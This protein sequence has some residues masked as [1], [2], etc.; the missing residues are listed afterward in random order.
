MPGTSSASGLMKMHIAIMIGLV[1]VA[2]VVVIVL[3][4][5]PPAPVPVNVY[6]VNVRA[7]DIEDAWVLPFKVTTEQAGTHVPIQAVALR[8]FTLSTFCQWAD[9]TTRTFR[10]EAAGYEPREYTVKG[11][12]DIVAVLHRENAEPEPELPETGDGRL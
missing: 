6:L 8:H 5:S 12:K 3:R 4:P 2:V 10:V 7:C 9:W 1:V 11:K